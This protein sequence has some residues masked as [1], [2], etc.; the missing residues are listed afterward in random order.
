ML[1]QFNRTIDYMRL[2]ITDRCNLRCRYCMPDGVRPLSHREIL[3]Y[4]EILQVAET[5]VRLGIT[6]FKVT[7]GEP[8]VRRDCIDFLRR[9]KALPGVESVTLT[10]NGVLLRPLVPALKEL[11]LDGVNI[12]LD[13]CDRQEYAAITGTD[14]LEQVLD[15]VTACVEAGLHTKINCVLLPDSGHRLP[16]LA[17]LAA[18]RPIDVRFIEEMPI[19]AGVILKKIQRDDALRILR[20]CWPDLQP[21]QERRGNGPAHYYGS[22]GLVGRIGF[23][24]A[25]SHKFCAGCNRVRLTSTGQLKPCLCYGESTDLREILRSRPEKLEQALRQAIEQKPREHCFDR[26]EAITEQNGMSRIGG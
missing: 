11:G 22:A 3:T 20:G 12:S 25:V 5:A 6:K 26:P 19:G 24:D 15:A 10:T 7:G 9:L 16:Q 13:S 14:A 2:S 18:D 21:V 17:G 4:E 1:D 8:L 23:I